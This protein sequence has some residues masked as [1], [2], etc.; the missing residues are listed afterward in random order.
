MVPFHYLAIP[1]ILLEKE[2][3]WWAASLVIRS[4][5]YLLSTLKQN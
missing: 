2:L 3:G 4:G 1:L 5:M